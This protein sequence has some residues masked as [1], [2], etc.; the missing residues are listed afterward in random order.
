VE[1]IFGPGSTSRATFS[2]S[3]LSKVA[4]HVLALG[5]TDSSSA[6]LCS[7]VTQALHRV[8]ISILGRIGPPDVYSLAHDVLPF[9]PGN[10]HLY[11]YG[12]F[13]LFV[14]L[15]ANFIFSKYLLV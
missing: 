3:T 9:R 5:C 4:A 12:L 1:N 10:N 7:N 13:C 8:V 2:D 11:Y 14:C 6:P 15:F